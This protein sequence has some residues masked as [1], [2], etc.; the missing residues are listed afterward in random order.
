MNILKKISILFVVPAL[1]FTGCVPATPKI[2]PVTP[3]LLKQPDQNPLHVLLKTMLEDSW[4]QEFLQNNGRKPVLE[5]VTFRDVLTDTVLHPRRSNPDLARLYAANPSIRNIPPDWIPCLDRMSLNKL[6]QDYRT[7]GKPDPFEVRN[8]MDPSRLDYS[9]FWALDT[10]TQWCLN[11]AKL[12]QL[13]KQRQAL[14]LRRRTMTTRM[15]LETESYLIHTKQVRVVSVADRNSL[16][17]ER[18]YTMSHASTRS[19]Q[20]PG[21]VQGADFLLEVSATS[22]RLLRIRTNE[23]VWSELVSDARIQALSRPLSPK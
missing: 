3:E 12:D 16:S 17:Y 5:V 8:P 1:I 2:I 19:V 10:K 22:F 9:I 23:V 14:L 21:A 18:Y 15:A 11:N 6:M 20:A 13:V 7:S 4:Y